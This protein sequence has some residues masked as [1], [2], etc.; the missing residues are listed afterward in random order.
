M[1][2]ATNAA[3]AQRRYSLIRLDTF[4]GGPVEL[5]S[6]IILAHPRGE[7]PTTMM[8]DYWIR[9]AKCALEL[10]ENSTGEERARHIE[11]LCVCTDNVRL[12]LP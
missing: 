7:T 12:A 1:N 5:G 8:V 3:A 2:R 4:P 6:G 10:V 11:T 9:Q